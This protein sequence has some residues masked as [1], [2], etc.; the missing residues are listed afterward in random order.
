MKFCLAGTAAFKDIT[1]KHQPKFLLES[2]YYIQDWQIPLIKKSEFFLLDSGAYTFMNNFKGRVNWDKYVEKYARF[3]NK[4]DVKYFFELDIDSIVGLEEVKRLR[5]KLEKLTNKKCIP[6][7]HK[8]RGLEDY[9]KICEEY[10]YI[11]IGGIVAKEIKPSEHKFFLP[12][13]KIAKDNNCKVHGLGFTSTKDLKYYPF[14]SVDSTSWTSASRFAQI[15]F[16]DGKKIKNLPRPKNSKLINYKKA[17]EISLIE[18][19]KFQNYA[20][21]YL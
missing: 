4:Y 1:L 15:A 12:L 13:L 16:F 9:K 7:W 19:I 5:E 8:S 14:Y 2:F 17:L 6:V 21:N 10:D 3:I 11:A 20:N 18:W